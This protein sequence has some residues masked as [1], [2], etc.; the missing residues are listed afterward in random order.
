MNEGLPDAA[1]TETAPS[2][3]PLSAKQRR[4]LGTLME[5]SK[6][7]PD[8]YPMTFAGLT[9]GC[10]QK[11]NRDPIS[12][13]SSE[14]VE[15]VVDELKGIGAVTLVHGNGRTE[16]VRHYAYQWLGLGKVDAAIMTELLLRGHQTLGEL[17]T[18]ASRM[19]PIPDLN[20]LQQLLEGLAAK[21]LIVYLT[22]PGR[23][24]LVSH[25]L[26]PEWELEELQKTIV[27]LEEG[28]HDSDADESHARSSIR[29]ESRTSPVSRDNSLSSNELAS[30]K[31]SMADMKAIIH[32]LSER[33][34]HLERELGV[35]VSATVNSDLSED[36]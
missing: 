14:Q 24:Q 20:E 5:K 6:T 26:Y 27:V 2:W 7:T 8:A 29:S 4:V 21:K 12:N 16:K 18:R 31:A 3:K 13:Y 9:T 35:E 36:A 10:N 11:S 33:L 17:R 1:G 25:N 34:A 30:L 28:S 19:E 22:P 32:Q 15:R 23:G